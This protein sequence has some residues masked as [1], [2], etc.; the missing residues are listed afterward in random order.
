VQRRRRPEHPVRREGHLGPVKYDIGE[1]LTNIDLPERIDQFLLNFDQ[2]NGIVSAAACIDSMGRTDITESLCDTDTFACR[3]FNY[4]YN[5]SLMTWTEF[6]P[7]GN[8]APPVPDE[9]SGAVKPGETVQHQPRGTYP[10]SSGTYRY[11]GLP[12][13]LF[14]SDGTSSV[15][16]PGPRRHQVHAD[17]L[18]RDLRRLH[19][20]APGHDV[21]PGD[22]PRQRTAAT[23][24]CSSHDPAAFG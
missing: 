13:G 10:E 6:Q 19:W 14:S 24:P 4:T 22:L 11:S 1:G 20:R 9:D 7:T 12:F 15:R 2:D 8:P 5:E 16:V 23:A 17:R 3:C 18:P 21:T